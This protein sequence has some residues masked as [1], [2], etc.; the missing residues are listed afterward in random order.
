MSESGICSIFINVVSWKHC[1]VDD[2]ADDEE[3]LRLDDLAD[4]NENLT[5]ADRLRYSHLTQ[6]L[7]ALDNN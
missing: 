7:F 1:L 2:L 3:N 6:G 5:R 4:G